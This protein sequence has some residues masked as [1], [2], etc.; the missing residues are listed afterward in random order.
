METVGLSDDLENAYERAV[1]KYG[2]DEWF[3]LSPKDQTKAIYAELRGIDAERQATGKPADPIQKPR[4][5]QTKAED[6]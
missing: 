5:T 2:A 3:R 1:E 6:Q 4:S